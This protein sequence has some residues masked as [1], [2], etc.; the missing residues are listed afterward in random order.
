MVGVSW[1]GGVVSGGCVDE[2][3]SRVSAGRVQDC[4]APLELH[5]S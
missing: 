5:A 3:L 4:A 1:V 2:L